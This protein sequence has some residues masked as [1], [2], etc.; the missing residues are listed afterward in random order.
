MLEFYKA[1][2]IRILK[3]SYLVL[4]VVTVKNLAQGKDAAER[5]AAGEP[6][7]RKKPRS[8]ANSAINV[9]YLRSLLG[10]TN[11]IESNSDESAAESDD[12]DYDGPSVDQKRSSF[13]IK[14][15]LRDPR[16][17]LTFLLQASL[18]VIRT[19]LSL[20]VATL[21]GIL[22]SKLVKGQFSEFVKVLLGQW[23]TLGIPASMVNSL[24]TYTTRLCAVTINRKVSY[25]LLDKYL[26]SHHSFYS[27]NNLPS[28]KNKALSLAMSESKENSPNTRREANPPIYVSD[29]PVQFL[30]RDVGA[31][32][33]NASVLLNQLLKPTLDLILCSFKL[34]QSSSSGMMAEGTL[35][36]GL[37]VYFSNLC[38]KLIQPN[39]V[40]L[41]VKRTHL[42]GYFRSLHS[43]L[44]SSNEEIALFK[45]Q[46][47]ELWNLDFSFYQLTL[48]LAGEIKSRALYDFATSFVV[49][50]VWGAAGLILCSIPV[51]FR[52]NMAEDVTADF[53]TNRRLLL[54]ASASIGRYVEL[55]RS[56]Q[57]L[58]GEALRLTNFNDRLDAGSSS[59]TD[60]KKVIIEYDDS[61]IQFVHV[62]L[63]TPAN[64]VLIPELNFE[65]KHGNHLLIIG[66]NGCGKSSLFRVLGGLWPVLQSFTNPK[67]PTKLIMPRRNAEN[68]ESPIYYL[69]Q[70]AYMSNL[71]TF[72]EQIIYPD[73]INAFEKK[74]NGDYQR[75]DKEL[76]DI[77]SVL[78]LDDLIAENMALIMAKR[79]STEGSGQPT[80]VSLTEAFGI[81]RNWSEE[82][83]VG[84][85]QRLA[86]ARM[87]YHRPKFAVLD[88]C[89]S[90]VSPE[91]EQKMYTHAQSLNIS[92]I[93]VCHRTTLWHFHNLLLKFD[94]N[95]GYTFGPFDPE[96]RLT[97]EQRLA[98]LNK[99]I[100]QDV[101]IWKKKLD[102]LVIAKKSNVL[103]KSQT[104]LKSLQESRLPLIQGMSPMTSNT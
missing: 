25:H 53:I 64:Q 90:A 80:E 59:K 54:T 11:G 92:L 85:Q 20:R 6:Q 28:D 31:F 8:R 1:H 70:R 88:E 9:H 14:L 27:V 46:S 44:R 66:P 36:L 61:K 52:S 12:G 32:S 22:V 39:F 71:S 97:D 63:V 58:K 76:A 81:T 50:Y 24:L 62:P 23:M 42:E 100:E 69:P 78:E 57:Q 74:Y 75:G 67:K 98:E 40:Q 72:R 3:A 41:T 56:I 13:L 47:T 15:L 37:I 4:L 60:G 82:L 94:G 38:L 19:M 99:I 87:Y 79:S 5:K 34:A 43:K 103:R 21:D 73:K 96:Q 93:S 33:Y 84:I 89:T 17:L 65:L 49:K 68:G 104:N 7:D 35:V 18:L 48:F 29:I 30:T 51:F 101:P 95:G 102:E 26:S 86:M 83:S 2:R 77:L 10:Q 45:G 16:C 55:R 91:M